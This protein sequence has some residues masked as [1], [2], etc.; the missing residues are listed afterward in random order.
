MNA[1]LLTTLRQPGVEP[2]TPRLTVSRAEH[3][4]F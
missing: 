1:N 4:A 2:L 3:I